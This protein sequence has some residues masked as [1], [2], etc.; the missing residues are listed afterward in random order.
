MGEGNFNY[1]FN[2]LMGYETVFCIRKLII[3]E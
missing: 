2:V 1:F 3:V